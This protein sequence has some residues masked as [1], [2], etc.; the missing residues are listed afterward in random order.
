[1][2]IQRWFNARTLA[3]STCIALTFALASV[4]VLSS[5]SWAGPLPGS[6]LE[7]PIGR[8][9]L[10]E[11]A[12]GAELMARLLGHEANGSSF[13]ELMTRLQEPELQSVRSELETKIETLREQFH[14][15]QVQRNGGEEV[16]ES[17]SF[18]AEERTVLRQVAAQEL[19]VDA[20][21]HTPDPHPGEIDFAGEEAASTGEIN[22]PETDGEKAPEAIQERARRGMKEWYKDSRTCIANR[23]THKNRSIEIRNLIQQL[24]ISAGLT[25]VGT[26]AR[27]GFSH[28]D[29]PS[30][31]VDLLVGLVSQ[32]VGMTWMRNR[33]TFQ[34]RWLKVFS[35]GNIRARLDAAF[36]R[37][38]PWTDTHGV[39]MEEAVETRRNYNYE[40]SAATSWISPLMFT[41]LNGM[42]CL[43]EED[44]G[45]AAAKRFANRAFLIKTG[46][47]VGTSVA[48]FQFRSNVVQ[49]N[50]AKH[51]AKAH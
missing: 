19:K 37:I 22:A 15:A 16:A 38:D 9:L 4:P 2:V 42:E 30:F 40:W 36:Y 48:Y 34:V 25:T 20:G 31:G 50:V 8:F 5:K 43:A 17:D 26:F 14:E 45:A 11:T 28:V 7:S 18:S 12:A 46:V 33:D 24:S 27:A 39:P 41:I 51:A 3:P 10:G 44:N 49:S 47:S 13:D 23:P 21:W 32:G 29:I 35:W 1:M 6:A